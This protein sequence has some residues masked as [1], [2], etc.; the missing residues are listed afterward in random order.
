[1]WLLIPVFPAAWTLAN[2]GVTVPSRAISALATR[3]RAN[4]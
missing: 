2:A 4:W 1:M 3:Y